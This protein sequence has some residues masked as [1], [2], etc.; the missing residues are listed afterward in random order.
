MANVH[1][2]F[3]SN[4]KTSSPSFV[5]NGLHACTWW[6]GDRVVLLVA[7]VGGDVVSTKGTCRD[8]VLAK[9]TCGHVRD[10]ASAKRIC[11]CVCGD[12]VA[13]CMCGGAAAGLGSEPVSWLEELVDDIKMTRKRAFECTSEAGS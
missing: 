5:D 12:M 2:K 6:D 3:C 11:G 8:V 10:V 7:S 13:R 4:G 9:R 1:G